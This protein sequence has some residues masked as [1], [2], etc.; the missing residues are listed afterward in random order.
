MLDW[1]GKEYSQ[2]GRH[3]SGEMEVSGSYTL[4]GSAIAISDSGNT[5]VVGAPGND[6]AGN[7][8]GH[9]RIYSW[10]GFEWGLQGA[11]IDGS[12]ESARNGSSVGVSNDGTR[13]VTGSPGADG[14]K[15]EAIVFQKKIL[16]NVNVIY[17][18]AFALDLI[19]DALTTLNNHRADY[20]S[21]LSR[22]DHITDNLTNISFNTSVARG[23]ILDADYVD[24]TSM[25]A[26]KKIATEAALARVSQANQQASVVPHLLK[27]ELSKRIQ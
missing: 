9:T 6:S 17:N 24:E 21:M 27:V 5:L 16:N 1:N 13:V 22:I 25:L 18:S 7:D 15:G 10:N 14:G 19:K 26:S 11:G 2:R 23:Q 4:S 3:I 8:A 20:G 12:A